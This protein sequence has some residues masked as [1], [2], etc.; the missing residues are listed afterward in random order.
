[1]VQKKPTHTI[2]SCSTGKLVYVEPDPE[3]DDEGEEKQ[4]DEA[5]DGT[6]R[7]GQQ[8]EGKYN[9]QGRAGSIADTPPREPEPGA[10][11]A[12]AA[13]ALQQEEG[14]LE[15]KEEG[16]KSGDG[17]GSSTAVDVADVKLKSA[18]SSSGQLIG[19]GQAGQEEGDGAVA[20]PCPVPRINPCLTVRGNTL[21]VYGGLLEVGMLLCALLC[22]CCVRV[23]VRTWYDFESFLFCGVKR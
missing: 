18:S 10:A 15:E 2:I 9:D 20:P 17:M 16:G 8:E 19:V 6:Q 23:H 3:D 21:Y 7:Q 11:A 4:T 12:A 22:A 14:G 1:M 13:A 5:Q